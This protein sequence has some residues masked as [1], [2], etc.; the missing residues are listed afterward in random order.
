[1]VYPSMAIKVTIQN[2][3]D[4]TEVVDWAV[5]NCSG[6]LYSVTVDPINQDQV[7]IELFF[8]DSESA[9]L[10]NLRYL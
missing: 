9:V 1:M 6:F 7:L 5:R 10:F 4:D 8:K 3:D 2:R